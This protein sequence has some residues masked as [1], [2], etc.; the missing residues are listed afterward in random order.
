[1]STTS[2]LDKFWIGF[3]PAIIVPAIVL[4]VVYLQTFEKHSITDFFH[5]LTR[6]G[7]LTQLLSLCVVPNL[8]IFFLFIWKDFLKGARGTLA[9]TIVIALSITII[10]VLLHSI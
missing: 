1:M 7:T 10:Q 2:K 8:G 5:F 4:S 3:F 6:T 9:A